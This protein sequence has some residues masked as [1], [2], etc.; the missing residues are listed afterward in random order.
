MAQ[1]RSDEIVIWQP[2]LDQVVTGQM[3]SHQCP[4]CNDAVL[5]ISFDQIEVKIRCPGCGEGFYGMLA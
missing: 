4:Y 2:I 5:E 1:D 3:A